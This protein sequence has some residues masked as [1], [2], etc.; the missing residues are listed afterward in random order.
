ASWLAWTNMRQLRWFLPVPVLIGVVLLSYNMWFF[1]S[2]LGGQAKLERLHATLHGTS[3]TW[4]GNLV[5]G[6]VGNLLS[7]NRG[8]LVFSPWILVALLGLCV[9]EV[10]RRLTAHSLI[11]AMLLSLPF[12]LLILSKYSVW[13][14]GHCFGPRY[15]TEAVPLF[16]ILF[17]YTLEWMLTRARV[18]V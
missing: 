4:S 2:I 6:M 14:G 5:D 10:R 11:V 8:R 7:P 12:Y 3:G 13:W 1:D 15:W 9:P 17:A 16:A 18:M